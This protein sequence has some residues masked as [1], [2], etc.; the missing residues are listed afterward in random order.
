VLH[1]TEPFMDPAVFGPTPVRI[2]AIIF[3]SLGRHV[4]ERQGAAAPTFTGALRTSDNN[5]TLNLSYRYELAWP[6]P[7]PTIVQNVV[8]GALSLR[9][10][11][12]RLAVAAVP[13][14]QTRKVIIPGAAAPPDDTAL[15][16]TLD[17]AGVN[18]LQVLAKPTLA[19]RSDGGFDATFPFLK[20]VAIEQLADIP[21]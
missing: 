2:D 18:L 9:E 8:S 17:A 10:G 1:L 15:R 4:W 12:T 6:G 7:T 16:A 21:T 13:A 19:P 20:R 5:L 11:A 3:D 14:V